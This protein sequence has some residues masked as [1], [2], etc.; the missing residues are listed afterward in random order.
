MLG[1]TMRSPSWPVL[2]RHDYDSGVSDVC[3]QI[4][5]LLQLECVGVVNLNF[6][7]GAIDVELRAIARHAET[8]ARPARN[9]CLPGQPVAGQIEPPELAALIPMRAVCDDRISHLLVGS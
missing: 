1:R 9:F 2:L 7:T 4:P 5:G 8:E 6:K 3:V